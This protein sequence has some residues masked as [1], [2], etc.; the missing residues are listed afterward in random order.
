MVP[1]EKGYT[2]PLDGGARRAGRGRGTAICCTPRPPV[3]RFMNLALAARRGLMAAVLAT[4]PWCTA[5][6]GDAGSVVLLHGLNRGAGSMDGI[7]DALRA[8]GYRVHNLD[9]PSGRHRV[10][11][12][13]GWLADRI[14]G[15]CRDAARGA[16]L[17]FVT[18]S[19]GGI[20]LRELRR[21]RPDIRIRRAVMLSPPNHGSELVDVLRDSALFQM[22]TGP[23]G[24]ELGTDPGSAPNRLGP[25]DFPLGV[26]AGRSSLNPLYSWLIPGDDDGTVAVERTRVDGM[27]D[28]I[29]IG[30]NHTFV[31]MDAE[32]IRQV[33]AFLA[34]GAFDRRRTAGTAL[35]TYSGDVDATTRG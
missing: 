13:A 26:V 3:T 2:V 28:F 17:D 23:A 34:R 18:H 32:A 35:R 31:M 6:G 14:D 1:P 20:L 33:R 8:D 11:R 30:A 24:Q 19:L 4:A 16:G 12:L 22:V 5:A 27:A 21:R 7:A 15:C 9:Y 10:A 29:V 25:V